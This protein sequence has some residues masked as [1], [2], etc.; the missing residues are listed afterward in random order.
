[1]GRKILK[2]LVA[3]LALLVAFTAGVGL[4]YASPVLFRT[5]RYGAISEQPIALF[6]PLR[7]RIP[8]RVGD[9]V[10]SQ[11][12]SGENKQVLESFVRD[13]ERR[14]H[15]YMREA[16]YPIESWVLGD[17]QDDA[18]GVTLLY[19]AKRKNYDYP[20]G[21]RIS[22]RVNRNNGEWRALSYNPIY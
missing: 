9:V 19:W 6:N 3:I 15:V 7:D 20:L 16:E 14:K 2:P 1:M 18:E 8:E 13:A 10:L 4:W 21:A 5:Y 22:I 12:R 17:R 11:M